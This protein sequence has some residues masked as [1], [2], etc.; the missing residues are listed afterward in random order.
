MKKL[1]CLLLCLMLTGC[2]PI[3]EHKQYTATF[4]TVFDTVTTVVGCAE[5]EAAFR[6]ISQDVHDRLLEWSQ[7]ALEKYRRHR[8]PDSYSKEQNH[9]LLH[10]RI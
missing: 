7:F 3:R 9:H 8:F 4:L 2:G 6:E 10:E 5:S 1:L